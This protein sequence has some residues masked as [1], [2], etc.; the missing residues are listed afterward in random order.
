MSKKFQVTMTDQQVA[1]LQEIGHLLNSDVAP[2]TEQRN[3]NAIIHAAIKYMADNHPKL[4]G[5][6]QWGDRPMWGGS[7]GGANAQS[8]QKAEARQAVKMAR[9]KG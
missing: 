2:Q 8:K 7:R 9:P 4:K 6:I 3:R 5:K 1:L